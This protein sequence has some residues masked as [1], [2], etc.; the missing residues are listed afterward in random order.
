MSLKL[1]F[2]LIDSKFRT[3]KQFFCQLSLFMCGYP[4]LSAPWI[5]SYSVRAPNSNWF[6]GLVATAL[7]EPAV[8]RDQVAI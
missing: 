3:I 5:G 7:F 4:L 8:N 2:K 6:E 1:M